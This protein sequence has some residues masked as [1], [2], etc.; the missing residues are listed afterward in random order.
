[1][2]HSVVMKG[3]S[4]Q[5]S[6]PFTAAENILRNYRQKKYQKLSKIRTRFLES[7]LKYLKPQNIHVFGLVKKTYGTGLIDELCFFLDKEPVECSILL[8]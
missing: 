8:I 3:D 4:E 2:D 1:M 7:E 5:W 6:T